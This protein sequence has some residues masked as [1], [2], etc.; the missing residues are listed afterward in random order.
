MQRFFTHLFH[1]YEIPYEAVLDAVSTS[2]RID[3]NLRKLFLP[4]DKWMSLGRIREMLAHEFEQHILRAL[5]GTR[6]SLALLG[7][8]TRGYLETE[9]GFAT[10]YS[11]EVARLLGS[12]VQPKLWIGTLATGLASGA[13]C[14]PLTFSVLYQVFTA[15]KLLTDLLAGKQASAEKLLADARKYAQ[16]R[17]L[18]TFRGVSDLSRLGIC[19]TKDILYQRGFFAVEAALREDPTRFDRLMVGAAGI[20]QLDDLAELGIVSSSTAHRRL[21]TDPALESYI[22]QFVDDPAA[23]PGSPGTS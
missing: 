8:G 18:R 16:N 3:P 7:S 20:H 14:P 4:A 6:S 9:E 13:I 22:I 10:Y 19:S 2:E 23:R 15:V 12:P 5:N 11:L 17:C 1:L 21:A